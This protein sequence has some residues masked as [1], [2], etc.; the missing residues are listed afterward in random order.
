MLKYYDFSGVSFLVD[1][2][3]KCEN[4][5]ENAAPR[6]DPIH[7]PIVPYLTDSKTTPFSAPSRGR[8]YTSGPVASRGLIGP[9]FIIFIKGVA[10]VNDRV[11]IGTG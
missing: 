4:A 5:S 10:S 3:F 6:F 1:K 11:E 9:P 2:R 8:L 7:N